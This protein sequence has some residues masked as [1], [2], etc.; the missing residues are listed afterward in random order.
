MTTGHQATSHDEGP[1]K[2]S[3][4]TPPHEGLSTGS[5]S[6][7]YGQPLVSVR[8]TPG[9]RRRAERLAT[10]QGVTLSELIRGLVHDACGA[11]GSN[12][13]GPLSASPGVVAQSSAGGTCKH[14]WHFDADTTVCGAHGYTTK[15]HYPVCAD[16]YEGD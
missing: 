1:M 16:R 14:C 10:E 12:A 6:K 2:T 9:L 3:E 15:A 5:P 7:R 11:K 13:E 8:M 4:T